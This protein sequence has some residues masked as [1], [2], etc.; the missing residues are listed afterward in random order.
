MGILNGKDRSLNIQA[1]ALP[2]LAPAMAGF[3]QN[4]TFVR[5]QKR[6]VSGL[7]QEVDVPVSARA[8]RVPMKAQ[9]VA[10]KPEGQR[11]W[12]WEKLYASPELILGP[13]DIVKFD[14]Q[15]YRVMGKHDWKEYAFVEYDLAQD[16]KGEGQTC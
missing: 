13:D 8:V 14:G 11:T 15:P 2:N 5:V 7:V 9:E 16:F 1:S 10:L 3:F 6:N 4:M 12:K